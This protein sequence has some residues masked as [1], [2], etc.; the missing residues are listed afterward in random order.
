[1]CIAKMHIYNISTMC[2]Y[3]ISTMCIYNISTMCIYNC[4][5]Q[6]KKTMTYIIT[7]RTEDSILMASDSRLNYFN[8]KDINGIK[9]QEIVA[10]ADC[11][12]KT[13]FI[14]NAN[15]GIQ[16]LGIGYFPEN[17]EKYPLS[18]FIKKIENLD[19]KND[20]GLDSKIVFDFF[21]QLSKENDTG[22]YVKGIMTGF[23]NKKAFITNFNTFNGDFEFQ[24]LNI[25]VQIDSEKNSELISTDRNDAV[26]EIKNR[27]KLK[28]ENSWWNIGG[29]ID[30][31]EITENSSN[32]IERNN[33]VFNGSQKE[34][35]DR[36]QNDILSIKGR[37]LKEAK[38]IPYKM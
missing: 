38:I 14:K 3:N 23:Q 2:I 9:H 13:F 25:G 21:N 17:D 33:T 5:T 36:F 28:E 11:V 34:L 10:T 22:Q 30:L 7:K 32:F 15:I 20:F 35:I 29:E 37:I 27:I 24:E 18:H 8:D 1:L 19:F 4:S 16:F 26:L 6:F 12:Q 31:L